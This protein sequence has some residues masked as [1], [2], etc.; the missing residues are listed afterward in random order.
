MQNTVEV[1]SLKSTNKPSIDKQLPA[2]A[3]CSKIKYHIDRNVLS[4]YAKYVKKALE[5]IKSRTFL[6]FEEQNKPIDRTGINFYSSANEDKVEISYDDKKPTNVRLTGDAY[7]NRDWLRFYIGYALGL[8]PEIARKDRDY[9]VKV[10]IGNISN[11]YKKY[12]EIRKDYPRIYYTT[13]FDFSSIMLLKPYFGNSP[14]HNPTYVSNVYPHYEYQFTNN[15]KFSFNDY[16][17]LNLL[18][19]ENQ[20]PKKLCANYGYH[21]NS[22][23]TCK[24]V[25][26]FTGKDCKSFYKRSKD[27]SGN[28]AI[29]AKPKPIGKRLKNV[30]DKCYYIIKSDNSKKKVK[31]TIKK[32]FTKKP[33]SCEILIKYRKD[34]GAEGLLIRRNVY[35]LSLPALSNNVIVTYFSKDP[36]NELVIGYQEV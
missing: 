5:I 11:F 36:E 31:F 22:C 9:N 32:F 4:E 33:G 27:C 24:C 14:R 2:Y 34:K 12:F 30:P 10:F 17:R 23:E 1:T 7:V 6:E 21:G 15:D 25:F 13:D 29:I 35:N 16:K 8:I 18:Y 28:I 20:C 26:P 19:C 3:K